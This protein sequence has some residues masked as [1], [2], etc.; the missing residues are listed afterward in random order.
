[1]NGILSFIQEGIS[2]MKFL[3]VKCI[4]DIV[5]TGRNS[6]GTPDHCFI[7]GK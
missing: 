5:I 7:K 6:N 4:E 1:M 3:L 2:D